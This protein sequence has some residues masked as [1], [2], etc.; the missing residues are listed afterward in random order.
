VPYRQRR[1]LAQPEPK[2]SPQASIVPATGMPSGSP[3]AAA[4]SALTVPTASCGQASG[5]SGSPG[6]TVAVHSPI[7]A[8]SPTS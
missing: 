3:V 2:T 8:F 6:A 4:A 5:G 7:Q 1:P